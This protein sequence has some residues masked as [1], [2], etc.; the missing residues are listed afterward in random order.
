MHVEQKQL[1][2]SLTLSLK[3]AKIE[4]EQ[5]AYELEQAS[6]MR[7]FEDFKKTLLKMEEELE[8]IHSLKTE[9]Y[10]AM[11][12]LSQIM[13]TEVQRIKEAREAKRIK[14]KLEALK[15]L[16]AKEVKKE[17]EQEKHKSTGRIIYIGKPEDPHKR[18]QSPSIEQSSQFLLQR[19]SALSN[20]HISLSSLR[21]T[22]SDLR[23]D[24]DILQQD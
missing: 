21:P 2:D 15:K 13:L 10:D 6:S 20:P 8:I 17:P 7:G 4:L 23:E 3:T 18:A 1:V 9:Q 14:K 22:S 24:W 16:Q 12:N 11:K 19:D 5:T